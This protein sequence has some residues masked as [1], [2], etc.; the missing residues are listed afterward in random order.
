MYNAEA[1]ELEAPSKIQL[2][3]P[4]NGGLRAE[5]PAGS[6]GRAAGQG[7]GTKLP[8][9]RNTFGFWAFNGS[10]KFAHFSKIWKCKKF[11]T[12]CVVSAKNEV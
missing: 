6:S 5:P 7:S 11:D 4:Y 12:I 2:R 3:G 8:W 9:N 10:R 1:R